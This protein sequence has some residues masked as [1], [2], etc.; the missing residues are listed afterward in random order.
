MNLIKLKIN[1]KILKN[2]FIGGLYDFLDENYFSI[3]FFL[4]ESGWWVT[5]IFVIQIVYFLTTSSKQN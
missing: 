5:I 4:N 1:R 3:T 2:L